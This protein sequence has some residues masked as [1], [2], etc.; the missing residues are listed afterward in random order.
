[1]SETK[2]AEKK[3][4]FR[5]SVKP[6]QHHLLVCSGADEWSAP[7]LEQ[8]DGSFIQALSK[9]VK[10]LKLDKTESMKITAISE[11]TRPND[12]HS[13]T[14]CEAVSESCWSLVTHF[15]GLC[16]LA[17]MIFLSSAFGIVVSIG[18]KSMMLYLALPFAFMLVFSYVSRL[19]ETKRKRSYARAASS[20]ESESLDPACDV[21]T[22]PSRLRWRVRRSQVN[23]FVKA[24]RWLHKTSS[25]DSSSTEKSDNYFFDSLSIDGCAPLAEGEPLGGQLVLVCTHGTRDDR[26]GRAGPPLLNAIK[27]ELLSRGIGPEK[28]EVLATSHIGGHKFAGCLIVYPSADWYGYLTARNARMIVDHL[29]SGKRME[30]KWRGNRMFPPGDTSACSGC[31]SAKLCE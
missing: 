4:T 31:E 2:K 28:I 6:H 25:V 9:A 12:V 5:G 19:K 24:V 20:I 30:N 17:G 15:L 3:K 21:L 29:I 14:T 23:A 27:S 18:I 7:R 11:P 13:T 1:M 10:D 8:V 16:A 22:F 26:C